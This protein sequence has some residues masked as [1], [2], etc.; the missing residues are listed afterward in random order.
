MLPRRETD[1][2]TDSSPMS[3]RSGA[4]AFILKN[5]K[6]FG[7]I[8]ANTKQATVFQSKVIA[9][10]AAVDKTRKVHNHALHSTIFYTEFYRQQELHLNGSPRLSLKHDFETR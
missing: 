10:K 1:T 5:K 8:R 7:S 9:V 6:H 3:G 2:D 4:G